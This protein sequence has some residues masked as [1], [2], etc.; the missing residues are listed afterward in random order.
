MK[1]R[2]NIVNKVNK[3]NSLRKRLVHQCYPQAI[4]FRLVTE[5]LIHTERAT[6]SSKVAQDDHD[7]LGL[8]VV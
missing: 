2:D 4:A 5:E 8:I 1:R 7:S 6:F 3:V